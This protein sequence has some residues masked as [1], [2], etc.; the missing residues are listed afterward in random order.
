[1]SFASGKTGRWYIFF[2]Y[3]IYIGI[4]A[5]ESTCTQTFDHVFI[6]CQNYPHIE[7]FWFISENEISWNALKT[8]LINDQICMD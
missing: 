4:W 1:M 5:F 7:N 6:V 3:P 2:K 8:A